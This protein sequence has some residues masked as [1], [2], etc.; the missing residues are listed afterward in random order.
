MFIDKLLI[1]KKQKT[2]KKSI[3]K[4]ISRRI[5]WTLDTIVLSR[6]ITGELGMAA[7]IGWLELLTKTVFYYIH[8]RAREK[9]SF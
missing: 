9:V 6:L 4:S 2:R 8:E 3:I 7:S 5:I 1:G